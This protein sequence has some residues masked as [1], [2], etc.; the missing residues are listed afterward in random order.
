MKRKQAG[1][2]KLSVRLS[3]ETLISNFHVEMVILD[4]FLKFL[5]F[6][7]LHFILIIKARVDLKEQPQGA[8]LHRP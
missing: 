4:I 5:E 2:I 1:T 3:V 8:N 6:R 7:L